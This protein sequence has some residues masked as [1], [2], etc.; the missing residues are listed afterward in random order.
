MVAAEGWDTKDVIE[1]SAVQKYTFKVGTMKPSLHSSEKSDADH[2]IF[3]QLAIFIIAACGFGLPFS[4]NEPPSGADGS[5]SLQ[6]ALNVSSKY[7]LT[8]TSAPEWFWKL[9]IAK[10]AYEDSQY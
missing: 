2:V 4:W 8:R 3:T 1:L 10:Y 9:P 6:E 7:N 5:M